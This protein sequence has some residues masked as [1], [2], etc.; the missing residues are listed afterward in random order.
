MA[1]FNFG[2]A[3]SMFGGG[4]PSSLTGTFNDLDDR[5]HTLDNQFQTEKARLEGAQGQL[6]ETTGDITAENLTQP[7]RE[8]FDTASADIKKL[9]L[10]ESEIATEEIRAIQANNPDSRAGARLAQRETIRGNLRRSI[11]DSSANTLLQFGSALT[12]ALQQGT[13]LELQAQG[14]INQSAQDI[15]Q[16]LGE[17]LK[18]QNA[19]ALGTAGLKADAILKTAKMGGVRGVQSQRASSPEAESPYYTVPTTFGVGAT[20]NIGEKY[21]D[22]RT[23][24]VVSRTITGN[25]PNSSFRR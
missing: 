9:A 12:T 11:A 10:A 21:V 23:G 7:L 17:Y 20:T 22:R 6:Q 18:T 8:A 5:Q 19:F 4:I 25:V 16:I 2:F 24:K 1:S 3:N 14:Q 13:G 15:T